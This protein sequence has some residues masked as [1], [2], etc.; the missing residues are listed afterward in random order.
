MGALYAT[1]PVHTLPNFDTYGLTC[2]SRQLIEQSSS[3]PERWR[4]RP[5]E[6]SA[7]WL[8]AVN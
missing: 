6:T 5:Y 7:T 3:Y 2:Y 8:S 1:M 4:D